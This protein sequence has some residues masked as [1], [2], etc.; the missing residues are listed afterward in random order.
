[1]VCSETPR[2][3]IEAG[4]PGAR[5][6][7]IDDQWMVLE[8]GGRPEGGVWSLEYREDLHLTFRKYIV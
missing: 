5:G 4:E 2:P 6:E 7:S 8:V 3:R 1:M